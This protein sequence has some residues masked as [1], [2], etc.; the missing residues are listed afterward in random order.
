MSLVIT[1]GICMR[2]KAILA[3]FA[4]SWASAGPAAAEDCGPLRG[5]AAV[6]LEPQSGASLV[7][8]S[9][10]GTQEKMVLD[11]GSLLSQI[12]RNTVDEL[13][14]PDSPSDMQMFSVDG[15]K[16]ARRT[17]LSQFAIGTLRGSGMT[18]QIREDNI[19]LAPGVAAAGLLGLD[20]LMRFDI[21]IDYGTNQ[22]NIIS[23]DHCAGKVQYWASPATA[24]LPITLSR[25]HIQ[26]P[27]TIDGKIVNAIIDT[28]AFTTTM[29]MDIATRLFGLSSASPGMVL[30]G[31]MDSDEDAKIYVH[32]FGKL[33]FE[34]V[35]VSNPLILMIP[36]I[37]G[38]NGNQ[39]LITGGL[40]ARESDA[41]ALPDL[42]IGMDIL[43]KL[44]VYFAFKERKMYI[45]AAGTP[46]AQP[47]QRP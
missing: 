3:A 12:T 4:I 2:S 31:H 36:N 39:S 47:L 22:L 19:E 27:V 45:T 17:S 23:Q 18:F 25:G 13:H 42:L 40:I 41:L 38:K 29:S 26:I 10:N 32:A 34:G 7:P 6:T 37:V 15:K 24:I 28:G 46:A 11:T 20:P 33:S 35:E 5:I 14:L 30:H 44:H 8:V 43:R 9:I 21:D 1:E 16:S